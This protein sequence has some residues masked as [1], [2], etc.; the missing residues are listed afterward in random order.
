MGT[1]D[2]DRIAAGLARLVAGRPQAPYTT[3]CMLR[4]RY[5]EPVLGIVSVVDI[6]HDPEGRV[7]W[8]LREA[9]QWL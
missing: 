7:H 3:A 9:G 1:R 8:V 5:E 6:A 4:P 2:R